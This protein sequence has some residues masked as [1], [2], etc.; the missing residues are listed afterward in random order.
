MVSSLPYNF[1]KNLMLELLNK[2]NTFNGG[3]RLETRINIPNKDPYILDLV[4]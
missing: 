2:G 1:Y 4:S 3:N